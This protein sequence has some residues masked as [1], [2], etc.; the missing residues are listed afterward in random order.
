MPRRKRAHFADTPP[1][2]DDGR[3]Q[4][5]NTAP[6]VLRWSN[7]TQTSF[8]YREDTAI[9]F[10]DPLS[11]DGVEPMQFGGRFDPEEVTLRTNYSSDEDAE[12]YDLD[13]DEERDHER[14]DALLFAP[15]PEMDDDDVND[16]PVFKIPA[17]SDVQPR[18]HSDT[19]T[20]RSTPHPFPTTARSSSMSAL[21]SILKTDKTGA[22]VATSCVSVLSFPLR[23]FTVRDTFEDDNLSSSIGAI[24]GLARGNHRSGAPSVRASEDTSLQT[25]GTQSPALSSTGDRIENVKNKLVAWKWAR[26]NGMESDLDFTPDRRRRR[27]GG[28]ASTSGAASNSGSEAM[29]G[30]EGPPT[31]P[32]TR[33]ASTEMSIGQPDSRRSS[34]SAASSND[35]QSGYHSPKVHLQLP[36]L[37]SSGCLHSYGSSAVSEISRKLSPLTEERLG[38]RHRDSLDLTH[39]RLEEEKHHR[40]NPHLCSAKDSMIISKQR[41]EKHHHHHIPSAGVIA[42][43]GLSPVMDASPASAVSQMHFMASF[44]WRPARRPLAEVPSHPAEDHECV[45]CEVEMPRGSRLLSVEREW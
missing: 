9:G 5:T 24:A 8:F 4:R 18:H 2:E 11:D 41:L 32:N 7:E 19:S 13:L 12:L 26:D 34:K 45:I 30:E 1:E 25:S 33:K 37:P 35:V 42:T 20:L 36:Y 22:D 43:G 31:P 15:R 38:P 28:S 17:S 14:E 27:Y 10:N 6:S 40:P 23:G 21:H 3:L 44:K 16:D 39:Q 29:N